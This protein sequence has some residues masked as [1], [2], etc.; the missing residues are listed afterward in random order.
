M[1]APVRTIRVVLMD[2][3]DIVRFALAELLGTDDSF[4]VVGQ[5]SR[6]AD[7]VD[8]VLEHR[9]D[10][11]L[12]DVQLP[13][14]SGVDACRMIREAS[15]ETRCLML[16]SSDDD[17]SLSAAL[18]AGASGYLLKSL[19]P[20]VLFDALRRVGQ[21]ESLVDPETAERLMDRM[22]NGTPTRNRLAALTF[23][24]R[25]VLDHVGDGRTDTEIARLVDL[26]VVQIERDID[27]IMNKV[28]LYRRVQL[29]VFAVE[30]RQP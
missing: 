29:A 30:A 18:M 9:P 4:E 10:V 14:G 15:P 23:D 16:T 25:I 13:D 22:L 7:V 11:A 12:L 2:D 5:C 20:H 17:E 24:E 6:V 1:T 27:S 26:P 3:H 8:V 28:G 19:R 21:G